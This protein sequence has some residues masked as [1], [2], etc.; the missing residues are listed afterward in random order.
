[1]QGA[2][3]QNTTE[4]DAA[5]LLTSL[6]HATDEATRRGDGDAAEECKA[7]MEAITK[8]TD[9]L[10]QLNEAEM[11][12]VAAS[13]YQVAERQCGLHTAKL[14][15]LS[16]LIASISIPRIT[17]PSIASTMSRPLLKFD[18]QQQPLI[19]QGGLDLIAELEGSP[20]YVLAAIGD[21]RSGKS[22]VLSMLINQTAGRA[23][24]LDVFTASNANHHVTDGIDV[25]VVPFRDGH[26]VVFD[27]EGGNDPKAVNHHAVPLLITL[28]GPKLLCTAT[29]LLVSL[30][31][32]L[33][34]ILA[35]RELIDMQASR[36]DGG[37]FSS[38]FSSGSQRSA[39]TLN[40]PLLVT[41]TSDVG[42]V[43][44]SGVLPTNELLVLIN[45]HDLEPFEQDDLESCLVH[46]SSTPE[47]N[48]ARDMIKR[49]FPSRAIAT[50]PYDPKLRTLSETSQTT[51]DAW[52]SFVNAV[53]PVEPL[54][55]SGYKLDGP[56]LASLLQHAVVASAK[57]KVKL[58]STLEQTMMAS[59][60]QPAVQ[61]ITQLFDSRLPASDDS[62]FLLKNPTETLLAELLDE[63]RDV[64]TRE[65]VQAEADKLR[66]HFEQRWTA[67]AKNH[68]A[69]AR[70]DEEVKKGKQWFW[71]CFAIL[72]MIL[73]ASAGAAGAW[74]FL[75]RVRSGSYVFCLTDGIPGAKNMS[76]GVLGS[77]CHV[78]NGEGCTPYQLPM[79]SD[80]HYIP[81]AMLATT[82]ADV[83]VS[84]TEIISESTHVNREDSVSSVME[85]VKHTFGLGGSGLFQG[86]AFSL[87]FGHQNLVSTMGVMHIKSY[88]SE[89]ASSNTV[90]ASSLSLS[91]AHAKVAMD[92]NAPARSVTRVQGLQ[93]GATQPRRWQCHAALPLPTSLR[94]AC[95]SAALDS[96]RFVGAQALV[97]LLRRLGHSL[98]EER[99]LWRHAQDAD[100][101]PRGG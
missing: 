16:T 35:G 60:I 47:L 66:A 42:G 34:R 88:Y 2:S 48:T 20:L 21:T 86:I 63:L 53:V 17:P 64:P 30:L 28:V 90:L 41:S 44:S 45:K 93:R 71:C 18:A 1:M 91:L 43:S 98:R 99:R 57:G 39:A 56:Q 36:S 4:V 87:G 97:L 96:V 84:H 82:D 33:A 62:D 69:E 61:R 70:V 78:L 89:S 15:E 8:V 25:A 27:C 75:C 74:Y 38:W 52:A 81:S 37:G 51:Q 92:R 40:E 68:R 14:E 65:A 29:N 26:L 9:E 11:A 95:Q 94:R 67:L 55:L 23:L 79:Y 22:T 19:Q 32:T 3:T 58:V 6:Q 83:S 46:D 13:E 7:S 59:V 12:A 76:Q 24:D 101:H 5:S 85:T 54:A 100:L 72:V 73:L 31:D 49:C 50:L 77:K 80:A 10:K